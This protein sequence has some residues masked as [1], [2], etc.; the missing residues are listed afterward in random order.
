M[1]DARSGR[2]YI[3]SRDNARV[4]VVPTVPKTS[5]E[6][7]R[8]RQRVSLLNLKQSKLDSFW[9]QKNINLRKLAVLGCYLECMAGWL[10]IVVML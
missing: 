6:W 8:G 4:D 9:E 3:T 7:W 1:A 5:M 10:V 2:V